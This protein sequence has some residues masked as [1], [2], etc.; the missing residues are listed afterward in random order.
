MS[1]TRVQF[2]GHCWGRVF[3]PSVWRVDTHLAQRVILLG[4]SYQQPRPQSAV[5]GP[6]YL[7]QANMV[8]T[9]NLLAPPPLDLSCPRMGEGY[10]AQ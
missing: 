10:M 6:L 3:K 9:E 5:L 4:N 8:F 2:P 1:L 7:D